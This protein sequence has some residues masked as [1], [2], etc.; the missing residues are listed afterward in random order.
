MDSDL[1]TNNKEEKE[2]RRL[3]F[4]AEIAS[5]YY[6]QDLTQ[7]EIAKR[8]FISRTRV[9]RLL[10]QSKEKGLVEIKIHFT[11]TRHYELEQLFIKKFGLKDA[12]IFNNKNRPDEE[13]LP[14]IG[15]LA[16]EYLQKQVTPGMTFGLSWG[17]TI[18]YTVQELQPKEKVPINIVQVIGSASS[19]NSDLDARELIRQVCK[20][21]D[22]KPYYLNA[23]L[24]IREPAVK[25]ALINDDPFNGATLR[26]AGQADLVLT[27]IGSMAANKFFHLWKGY[28][29]AD[30]LKG[31]QAQG[32][33]GY[34]CARFYD[35]HGRI[36]DSPIN[37][38]IVGIAFQ[39]LKKVNTVIGVAGG[40]DKA[41]AILGALNGKFINVLI[42]DYLTAN[43]ILSGI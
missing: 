14:G 3:S 16:A 2:I 13:T 21:Y 32:A 28:L 29:N 36:I 24:Y 23:P 42:T 33:V 31:L 41:E 37:Q 1:M 10:K 34:L 9:S 19:D 17:K 18:S 20:L 15:A 5:L 38:R 8:L 27:G 26:L 11:G 25:S 30:D 39:D 35:R 12:R 6:E 40:P 22:G 43:H 4:L 7:A